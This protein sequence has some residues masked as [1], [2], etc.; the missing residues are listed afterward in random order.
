GRRPQVRHPPAHRNEEVVRGA[1]LLDAQPHH[2]LLLQQHTRLPLACQAGI[3]RLP[4]GHRRHRIAR[5]SPMAGVRWTPSV[6]SA[7]HPATKKICYRNSTKI[8]CRRTR[9][10]G[11]RMG[12]RPGLL[13]EARGALDRGQAFEPTLPLLLPAASVGGTSPWCRPGL[14]ALAD[15]AQRQ[16]C[17]LSTGGGEDDP[18]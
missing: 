7:Q 13:P 10:A 14:L 11:E 15:L 12:S 3:P 6:T 4:R 9:I 18:Y 1:L 16:F 17:L 8:E 5:P 2:E